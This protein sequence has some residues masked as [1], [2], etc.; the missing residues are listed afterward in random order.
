MHLRST[1]VAFSVAC[2]L[3]AYYFAF[4]RPL[5]AEDEVAR[6][7]LTT[8][9]VE[10]ITRIEIGRAGA[11]APVV[12]VREAGTS[13]WR[14]EPDPTAD[15]D[16]Q[17]VYAVYRAL[18]EH[19]VLT[20]WEGATAEH[21]LAAPPLVV[22]LSDG[23]RTEWIAFGGEFP[24][25]QRRYLLTGTGAPPTAVPPR[26]RIGLAA[27]TAADAFDHA[28]ES[29]RDRRLVGRADAERDVRK[30]EV[31][32]GELTYALVLAGDRWRLDPEGERVR[33]EV[34]G[35]VAALLSA[36]HDGTRPAVG[37][38]SY[39]TISIHW[40]GGAPPQVLEVAPPE[41]ERGYWVTDPASSAQ[42]RLVA[43]T[44]L[45]W[46]LAGPDELR[47]LELVAGKAGA[48]YLARIAIESEG[49][50]AVTVAQD[51]SRRLVQDPPGSLEGF[52]T[53]ASQRLARVL[54]QAK[55][56]GKRDAPP[57]AQ[58]LATLGLA[59]PVATYAV[60][61]RWAE[62][63]RDREA[64][65]RIDV[66][67]EV[68]SGVVVRVDGGALYLID[69]AVGR[70]LRS[71]TLALRTNRV[72]AGL[73][74]LQ[75]TALRF[76][77]RRRAAAEKRFTPVRNGERWFDGPTEVAPQH[78]GQFLAALD[79]ME[80]DHY[81]PRIGAPWPTAPYRL[82]LDLA[83]GV[84]ALDFEVLPDDVVR[85][86]CTR[87]GVTLR[88]HAVHAHAQALAALLAELATRAAAAR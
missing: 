42:Q 37:V 69:A 30:L 83:S 21:G 29:W 11:A 9:A 14:L 8:L 31:R 7:P 68:E 19:T 25:G 58:D 82:E 88:G 80:V 44:H 41:D 20:R 51:A 70:L 34:D 79:A 84:V 53:F 81:A 17:M 5:P 16:Q 6:E 62:R 57:T 38:A 1:L 50:P 64:S 15:V 40:A 76:F 12:L 13:R 47:A 67:V 10:E 85:L 36:R 45:E 87:D 28:V 86:A 56:L 49:G 59:P 43:R 26:A 4:E 46:L 75:T 22:T 18:H 33:R 55:I 71:G 65:T 61:R 72:M 60:L 32:R 77:D 63:G 39:A 3:G 23:A 66:G 48:Q 2:V 74:L 78:V 27:R 35:Q 73:D 54:D 52:S 24:G